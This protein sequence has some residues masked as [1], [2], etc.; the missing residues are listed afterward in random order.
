MYDLWLYEL[1]VHLKV[2][3]KWSDPTVYLD[4]GGVRNHGQVMADLN[5]IILR[6]RYFK[7]MQDLSI[8]PN[9]SLYLL[10]ITQRS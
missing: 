7:W 8:K 1:M 5:D 9:L 6:A 2:P 4:L 10:G 3:M